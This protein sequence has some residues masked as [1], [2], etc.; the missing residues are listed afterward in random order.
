MKLIP[1]GTPCPLT[2][3]WKEERL[4]SFFTVDATTERNHW[5]DPHDYAADARNRYNYMRLVLLDE[6]F[7]YDPYSTRSFVAPLNA[8][9]RPHPYW[10]GA[11]ENTLNSQWLRVGLLM[12]RQLQL[13]EVLKK[14]EFKG[15]VPMKVIYAASLI[16]LL[17][18]NSDRRI[19]T[20]VGIVRVEVSI[21]GLSMGMGNR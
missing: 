5:K 12:D 15:A 8:S 13:E 11:L 7:G 16:T 17:K 21:G 6:D 3:P 2:Y 1:A 4:P 14:N 19:G 18:G 10:E 20:W 9:L